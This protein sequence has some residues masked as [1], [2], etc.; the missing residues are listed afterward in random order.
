MQMFS[1]EG[2][3]IALTGGKGYLGSVLRER[4]VALGARVFSADVAEVKESDYR[5]CDVT[6]PED[7]A[8]WIREAA[9]AMGGIDA[10]INCA[11]YARMTMAEDMTPEQWDETIKVSLYGSFNCCQAAFPFLKDSKGSIVSVASIAGIVGLP[12]G[13]T[14][15]SAA[16]AGLLGMTRSLAVEWAKYGIRVNAIA[17]GQFDTGPLRAVMK[18]PVY[19]ASILDGIP[20]GRVGTCKEIAAAIQFLISDAASFITGHTLVADGGATI[21]G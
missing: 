14:H 11:A 16:K 9:Q 12:R 21:S 1:V 5:G 6:N 8:E 15:H 7:T 18:D 3:R 20:L 10:L 13:T 2:K 17:P 4:F 19:A